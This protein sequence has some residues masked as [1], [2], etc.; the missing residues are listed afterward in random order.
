MHSLNWKVV[1]HTLKQGFES[2]CGCQSN[3]NNYLKQLSFDKGFATSLG[4]A[5]CV[6][7][8]HSEHKYGD[9]YSVKT[10]GVS[11]SCYFLSF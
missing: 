3:L 7:R 9:F 5:D 1:S 4:F 11:N 8:Q 6:T 2:I 10:S